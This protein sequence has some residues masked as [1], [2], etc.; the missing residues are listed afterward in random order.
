M[1]QEL[2]LMYDIAQVSYITHGLLILCC[3]FIIIVLSFYYTFLIIYT[4]YKLNK[5]TSYRNLFVSKFIK[6]IAIY[7]I[8]YIYWMVYTGTAYILICLISSHQWIWPSFQKT[9]EKTPKFSRT[10]ATKKVCHHWYDGILMSN[11]RRT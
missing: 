1:K 6:T 9:G 4:F 5:L 10:P 7:Y 8:L 2:R 3:V 11:S